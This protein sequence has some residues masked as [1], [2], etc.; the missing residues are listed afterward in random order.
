MGVPAVND[1]IV[2]MA[3]WFLARLRI[4]KPSAWLTVVTLIDQLSC[5]CRT[6]DNESGSIRDLSHRRPVPGYDSDCITRSRP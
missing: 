6:D 5:S 4:L 1:E 2:T 3:H